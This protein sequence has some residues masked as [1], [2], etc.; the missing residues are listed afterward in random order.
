MLEKAGENTYCMIERPLVNPSR[1]TATISAL[2]CMEATEIVL[3]ELLIP[4]QWIDSKEWQ[5]V[6][7]P[8]GLKGDDLKVAATQVATRLYPR[9]KIVNADCLLIA[10]YNLKKSK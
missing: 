4:Y 9:L 3:E 6:V 10:L 8:S 7:L 2:R 5:K 1:F